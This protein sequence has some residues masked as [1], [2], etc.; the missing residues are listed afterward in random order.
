MERV[1]VVDTLCQITTSHFDAVE[2]LLWIGTDTGRVLSLVPPLLTLHTSGYAANTGIRQLLT[3]D[4]GLI[5]LSDYTVSLRSRSSLVPLWNI[6]SSGNDSFLSMVINDSD[7]LISTSFGGLLCVGLR[8]GTVLRSYG[9]AD[10]QQ[11]GYVALKNLKGTLCCA[12]AAGVIHFRDLRA[13]G[14]KVI[15]RIEA[16]SGLVSDIDINGQGTTLATTGYILTG[17]QMI[18]DPVI[19]LFDIRTPSY[20][21]LLSSVTLSDTAPSFLRFGVGPGSKN[22]VGCQGTG[23]VFTWAS[24]TGAVTDGFQTDL[25]GYMVGIDFCSTG[26]YFSVTSSSGTVSLWTEKK[27]GSAQVNPYERESITVDPIPEI[28]HLDDNSPLSLVGMPYYTTKLLSAT[29]PANITFEVGQ[30]PARIPKEVLADVKMSD[31]VGY[32]RNPGI[33]F[34]RN[35]TAKSVFMESVRKS[36]DGPK[37]RSEQERDELMTRGKKGINRIGARDSPILEASSTFANSNIPKAYRQ[38]QIKYSKFGVEDFD[39][40]FYNKTNCSGL[41]THIRNSYCNAMLQLLFFTNPL[42]EICK[43]HICK[44]CPK[45]NCLICELGFLFRMLEDAKGANCQ[46]TNFLYVFGKLQQAGALGLFEHDHGV[47]AAAGTAAATAV[48]FSVMMHGFHRFILETI[49]SEGGGGYEVLKGVEEASNCTLVQ[50]VMGIQVRNFSGCQGCKKEDVRDS[51]QFV[52][53]IVF[54]VKGDEKAVPSFGSLLK[55]N[56]H[57]ETSAKAWCA[58]CN[59]Y[60]LMS[61]SKQIKSLPNFIS[62]NLK[63]SLG[64]ECE[65]LM[66]TVP[67]WMPLR[68]AIVLDGSDLQVFELDKDAV[69]MEE[70]AGTEV[71]IYDLRGV[72]SEIKPEGDSL[73]SHLVSHLYVDEQAEWLLFN[74]FSVQPIPASD[75]IQFTKWK[76]PAVLQYGRVDVESLIDYEKLTVKKS[77]ENLLV[78]NP[79]LNR[80]NNLAINYTPL[81]LTEFPLK[82]GFLV[83][84][85]AEFVSLQKEETEI[86]SDGS[87]SMILPSKLGLAR[88]SVL[89]GEDGPLDGVPFIDDYIAIQD[90][91][92]DYLTEYSGISLGDLD[93]SSSL[94]P[95]VPLKVAYQKLRYLVDIGCIFVGHGLKKDFR[96]INIIVPPEQ[97]VDTVDI[98]FIKE[99]QRKLSL[100]FLSW[101]LLQ[102][103]I[104]QDTHDSIEDARAALLLYKKYLALTKEGIFEEVLEDIYEEGRRCNFKPPIK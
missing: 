69:K 93:P 3:T 77:L 44:T 45:P 58:R 76:S 5:V 37:F 7:L 28:V 82:A 6:A 103:D 19:K 68:I 25:D 10:S 11:P 98:F 35:Q 46:A 31:F 56:L 8:S 92:V 41:E 34:R 39:F 54:K 83:A 55:E 17:S 96:T 21:K 99:R 79:I 81:K 61:Q 62:L 70:F 101:S 78:K 29:W 73:K 71:A 42:R 85:D 26:D 88:V 60:Q 94:H 91:I 32:A 9:I 13:Q 27:D 38:V 1:G 90:T 2:A 74:D 86:R 100:R 48:S 75:V 104:Q 14:A 87:R 59:K 97:I 67:D 63:L 65:S 50:Q 47:A 16:H 66:E 30:P 40:G 24:T 72:I 22:F 4:K 80:R 52:V 53:D 49:S 43:A 18:P 89:R 102:S 64:E 84:I 95:L 36:E 33:G 57:K 15:G 20:P 12:T 51:V 23:E